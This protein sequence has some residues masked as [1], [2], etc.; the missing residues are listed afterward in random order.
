[1]LYCRI[2]ICIRKEQWP[3]FSPG[4]V[5][6][7]QSSSPSNPPMGF[8]QFDYRPGSMVWQSAVQCLGGTG[9]LTVHNQVL[10]LPSPWQC[11]IILHSDP[12][13]A[14]MDPGNST[15]WSIGAVMN[16]QKVWLSTRY[17]ESTLGGR[18]FIPT[19]KA[20]VICTDNEG[21]EN[22][23]MPHTRPDN[24]AW[25]WAPFLKLGRLAMGWCGLFNLSTHDP[26][27]WSI[28]CQCVCPWD[29]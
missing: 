26:F 5:C 14:W 6:F 23:N 12:Q 9:W 29:L 27:S 19:E 16:C 17:S 28:C 21:R 7:L 8:M 24:L 2:I 11:N 3:L 10:F 18:R 1:M 4:I 25:M 15:A 22:L 13:S 20:W